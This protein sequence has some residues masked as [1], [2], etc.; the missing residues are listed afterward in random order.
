MSNFNIEDI[1]ICLHCGSR[2][3]IVERQTE[4]LKGLGDYYNITWNK[5][6]DRYPYAYPSYS[7]LINDS[8]ATSKDE[9]VIFVNDR[10]FPTVDEGRKMLDHL[11]E[12]YAASFLWNRR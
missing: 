6:I 5:R 8:I 1:T 4:E 12:G 9:F 3:D 2:P 7:E 11:Q 10:C